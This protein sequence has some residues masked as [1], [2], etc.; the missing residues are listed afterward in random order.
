MNLIIWFIC[1]GLSAILVAWW[2]DVF[3]EKRLTVGVIVG[4]I[5]TVISG[6]FGLSLIV[7]VYAILWVMDKFENYGGN[8][9]ISW[10]KRK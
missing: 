9:V 8:T 4:L 5:V 6:T 3:N 10:G 7:L 2:C 1:G